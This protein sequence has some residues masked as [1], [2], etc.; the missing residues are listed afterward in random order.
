MSQVFPNESKQT[1]LEWYYV[2]LW[3][4]IMMESWQW[5]SNVTISILLK[6]GWFSYVKVSLKQED[7]HIY[8][9]PLSLQS[10]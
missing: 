4:E 10:L 3:E 7:Y 6:K 9:A 1:S 8:M 5:V 2:Y